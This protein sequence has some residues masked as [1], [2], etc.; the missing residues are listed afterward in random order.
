MSGARG[1]F[2]ALADLRRRF[3]VIEGD[4]FRLKLA[5][6]L[7]EE[8]RTQVHIGFEREEDPE[9]VPWKP[10]WSPNTLRVTGRL[11]NSI[12]TQAWNKGFTLATNVN[13]AAIHQ[14]GGVIKAKNA[15]TY[16][17]RAK[18]RIG[19][20]IGK[21]GSRKAIWEQAA[22]RTFRASGKPM[23]RWQSVTGYR[24]A[25][26]RGALKSPKAIKGWF[27]KDEVTIPRRRF[28]PEGDIGHRWVTSLGDEATRVMVAEMG[29]DY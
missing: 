20:V 25:G 11:R 13:Y 7:A 28:I 2:A 6:A 18:K 3:S 29:G 1:D 27:M 9:G 12:T 24:I 17:F 15:R 8:A 16:S 23:L 22:G 5:R 14:Y 4:G 21:D 19:R 10:S 26:A